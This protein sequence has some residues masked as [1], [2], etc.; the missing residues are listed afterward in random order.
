MVGIFSQLNGIEYAQIFDLIITYPIHKRKGRFLFVG[1]DASYEM[2]ICI[3]RHFSDEISYLFPYLN[4]QESLVRFLLD[5]FV[6]F[7]ESI[8]NELDFDVG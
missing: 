7:S 4:T 2:H 5:S 3:G 1:F 6:L 8:A